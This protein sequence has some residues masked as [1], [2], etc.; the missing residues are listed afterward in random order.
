MSPAWAKAK[1]ER[2]QR[3]I[4]LSK[5]NRDD[6]GLTINR[7]GT[8]KWDTWRAWARACDLEGLDRGELNAILASPT[9]RS[10]RKALVALNR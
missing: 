2:A 4:G 3:R 7:D 5:Q 1:T 6:L 10:A 9:M 8:R